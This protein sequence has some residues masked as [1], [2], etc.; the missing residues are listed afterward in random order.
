MASYRAISATCA[1]VMRLLRQTWQPALFNDT[2]LSFEVYRTSD[3]ENPMTVGVSLFLYDVR[4]NDTQRSYP[5]RVNP[6]GTRQRRQL[7]LDL[8]FILTPWAEEAAMEHEILGWLMRTL[9]D[10][11]TL[12][13]AALNTPTA[14]VFNESEHVE[15]LA[16]TLATEETIRIW[17]VLPA[18]FRLSVPYV[19][20]VVRIDSVQTEPAGEVVLSRELDFGAWR[21]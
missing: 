9:E 2:T 1:G 7:P 8:H 16:G 18:D 11:P 3:F 10:H 21:E 6:D 5:G 20:R 13:A 19:A 14:T 12:P 15:L 17:D 4:V